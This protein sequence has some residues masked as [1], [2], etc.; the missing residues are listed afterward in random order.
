MCDFIMLT[1]GVTV[2]TENPVRQADHVDGIISVLY[3]LIV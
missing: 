2:T 1:A 3:Y